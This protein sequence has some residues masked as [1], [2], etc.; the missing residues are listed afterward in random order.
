MKQ[1][2]RIMVSGLC[3]TGAFEVIAIALAAIPAGQ[4]NN[5]GGQ[6]FFVA[7]LR[8]N[9]AFLGSIR[10]SNWQTRRSDSFTS[11]RT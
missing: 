3:I 7:C 1:S 9:A 8:E 2:L 11:D 6:P 5:V 4:F 10:P